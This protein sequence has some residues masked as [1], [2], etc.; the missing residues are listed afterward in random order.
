MFNEIDYIL[1]AQ[2]CERFSSLYSFSNGKLLNPAYLNW[3]LKHI[4]LF[5]DS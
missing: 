5:I 4:N 3:L 1:E 2:N